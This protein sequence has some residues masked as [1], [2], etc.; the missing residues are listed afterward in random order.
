MSPRIST[1]SDEATYDGTEVFFVSDPSRVF[2]VEPHYFSPNNI[3]EE[4]NDPTRYGQWCARFL[5]T[6]FYHPYA[7]TFLRELLVGGVSQL[8]RPTMQSDPGSIRGTPAFDFD[9]AFGPQPASFTRAA[10]DVMEPY[11]KEASSSPTSE[12]VSRNTIGTS[13]II[14]TCSWHR[15]TYNTGT[16]TMRSTV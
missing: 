11:P 12:E 9:I 14:H 3:Y 7:K 2:F 1:P 10:R 13:S 15:F 6:P 8:M 16:M 4:L 5:F